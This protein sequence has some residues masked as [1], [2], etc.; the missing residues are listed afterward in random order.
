M[1]MLTHTEIKTVCTPVEPGEDINYII[2]KMN[3]GIREGKDG[4]GLAA[5][6]VGETKRII[7]VDNGSFKHIFLNPVITRRYGGTINSREGCLSFPGKTALVVRH[8][9]ITMEGLSPT[10]EKLAFKLKGLNAII[11]Q[12][13]VDHLDG[14][15]CMD[16]AFKVITNKVSSGEPERG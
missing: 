3:I 9:Q 4:L 16:K 12:H 8:K 7:M 14:I 13:E 5:N 2:A 10:G 1:S 11:I 6:Q 15:S